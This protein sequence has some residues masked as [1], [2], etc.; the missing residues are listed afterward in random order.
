[1]LCIYTIAVTFIILGEITKPHISGPAFASLP[2]PTLS[3]GVGQLCHTQQAVCQWC[4]EG[5]WSQGALPASLL[6]LLQPNWTGVWECEAVA[7]VQQT[8]HW[9]HASSCSPHRGFSFHHARGLWALHLWC[10]M[11]QPMPIN[12]STQLRRRLD[13]VLMLGFEVVFVVLAWH[14]TASI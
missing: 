13:N 4:S 7:E 1:M 11:L 2:L 3:C 10:C 8:V 12:F 6:S 9:G 5:A 14:L